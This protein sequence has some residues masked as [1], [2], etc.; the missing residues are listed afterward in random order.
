MHGQFDLSANV[1]KTTNRANPISKKMVN[2]FSASR[3][4]KLPS[5]REE[6]CPMH[7][8]VTLGYLSPLNLSAKSEYKGKNPLLPVSSG[9]VGY[10]V[11]NIFPEIPE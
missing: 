3:R 9:G 4:G 1:V 6:N 11:Q 7:R 5:P 8:S 2:P 10:G